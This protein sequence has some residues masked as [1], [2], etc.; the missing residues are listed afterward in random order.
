MEEQR[1]VA[2]RVPR[3]SNEQN[4]VAEHEIRVRE[5]EVLL[6]ETAFALADEPSFLQ[7]MEVVPIVP[8]R[9]WREEARIGEPC[10]VHAVFRTEDWS[11]VLR[12]KMVEREVVDVRA[13]ET[14]AGELA[15]ERVE[16]AGDRLC[17]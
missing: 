14:E 15:L 11:Q 9:T 12:V 8:L 3:R 10:R 6:L 13:R 5:N 16:A 2:A 17:N 1:L 4:A 7:R